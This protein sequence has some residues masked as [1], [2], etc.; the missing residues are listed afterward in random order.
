[1]DR[2]KRDHE[3]QRK[4]DEEEWTSKMKQNIVEKKEFPVFHEE[5]EQKGTQHVN[6][7]QQQVQRP[8]EEK[9]VEEKRREERPT[10]RPTERANIER[11]IE[12][13]KR[14]EPK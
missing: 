11:H 4:K 3:E 2:M 1:M 8:P 6:K 7:P 5:P 10:Q 14:E 13:P 9:K 12:T